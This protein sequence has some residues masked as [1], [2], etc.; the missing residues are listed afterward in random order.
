MRPGA[1]L[2]AL[3]QDCL[4]QWDRSWEPWTGACRWQGGNLI[5]FGC[6]SQGVTRQAAKHCKFARTS[7]TAK[8]PTIRDV[9]HRR[10]VMF[11]IA[12]VFGEWSLPVCA[13]RSLRSCEAVA[14]RL[15]T[16]MRPARVPAGFVGR[17]LATGL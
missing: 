9:M 15:P 10:I 4:G 6:V 2:S 12:R 17:P 5:T 8:A 14:S 7:S 13:I 1:T 11:I 3:T 16:G